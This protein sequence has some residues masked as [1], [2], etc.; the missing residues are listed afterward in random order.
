MVSPKRPNPICVWRTVSPP[1]ERNV[2]RLIS[3]EAF[4]R[5][6]LSHAQVRLWLVAMDICKAMAGTILAGA[7]A[8]DRRREPPTGSWLGA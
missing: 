7:F 2:I 5:Q 6:K 4:L 8:D 1:S 3:L